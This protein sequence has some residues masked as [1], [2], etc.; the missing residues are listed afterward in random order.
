MTVSHFPRL[1]VGGLAVVLAIGLSACSPSGDTKSG[2]ETSGDKTLTV[3]FPGTDPGESKMVEDTL[4]PEFEKQTGAKVSVTY[5]DYANLDQ[6][7]SA[8]F[9]AGTAPDVFGHGPAAA[10]DLVTNGRIVDLD[11]LVAKLSASDRKDLA[12]AL[13]GGKVGGKQYL[14]PLQMSGAVL[15]Y[16]K[17]DFTAAGLDPDD[18][19][20][21]WDGVLKDAQKLTV[22]DAS[23]KIT[24]SGLLLASDAGGGREQSFATLIAGA[25]GTLVNEKKGTASF[26]SAAGKKALN[27][28]VNLYQ[29]KDAVSTGLGVTY[30]ANAPAQQPLVLDSA[31]ITNLNAN[32]VAKIMQADPDLQIG[33][34]PPLKFD[35][36][37]HGA[38]FGG[39]G[40]GLMLNADSKQQSLGWKFIQ[41]MLGKD[42]NLQYVKS[43]GGIPVRAS[44]ASSDYVASSPVLSA[45]VKYA[46]D[47]VP[48]PNVPGWVQARDVMDT[49][50]EQALNK[51]TSVADTLSSMATD[52]D[53]VLTKSK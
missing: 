13:T 40:P 47:F 51:K 26:D 4:V 25:G 18:P 2:P 8:A 53:G 33:I 30:T 39:A 7:L 49:H 37:D 46:D 14:M 16:D 34:I 1:M 35:G 10:A 48:N 31:S 17:A 45:V 50:L 29:G 36:V 3:W 15:A 22:R 12:A 6:K 43:F 41:F 19:P 52:V 42:V 5:V 38:A 23:G 24:R 28:F 9:A 32:G 21:T 20:T 44:A 11:S 27:Y